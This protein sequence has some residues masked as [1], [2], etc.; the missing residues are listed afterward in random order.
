LQLYRIKLLVMPGWLGKNRCSYSASRE[1]RYNIISTPTLLKPF[2]IQQSIDKS[3]GIGIASAGGICF[4]YY[5]SAVRFDGILTLSVAYVADGSNYSTA[6]SLAH[7]KLPCQG[8][9]NSPL[10]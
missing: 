4:G 2:A 5:V 9:S 3:G 1:L 7:F 8:K 10:I 6:S